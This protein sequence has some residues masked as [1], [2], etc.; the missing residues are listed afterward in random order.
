MII[1]GVFDERELEGEETEINW[2]LGGDK[3]G[4]NNCKNGRIS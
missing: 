3:Y 1:Y 4:V 2:C